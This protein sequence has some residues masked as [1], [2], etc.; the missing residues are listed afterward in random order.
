MHK[1]I[2]SPSL[3]I[4]IYRFVQVNGDTSSLECA[5]ELGKLCEN[6]SVVVNLIPYNPTVLSMAE[7]DHDPILSSPP[8]E[9]IVEFQRI[10]QSYGCLCF[11]RKTMGQDILGA[12]GQ[13]AVLQQSLSENE[14]RDDIEDILLLDT[15]I[16][17]D[18]AIIKAREVKSKRSLLSGPSAMSSDASKE[19]KKELDTAVA[20]IED[21]TNIM[22]EMN[23]EKNIAACRHDDN[24]LSDW[25]LPLIIATSISAAC[26][27]VSGTLLLTRRK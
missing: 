27:A 16:T 1:S 13:L 21:V 7:G 23:A 12:C 4:L 17:A 6:R 26:F 15:S 9:R 18:H 5:H 11:V 3:F 2:L 19:G 14:R 25:I 24:D 20:S 22:G 10:V 8:Y